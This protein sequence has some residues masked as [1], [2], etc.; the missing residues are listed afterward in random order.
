MVHLNYISGRK[1]QS[2]II[3]QTRE[4]RLQCFIKIVFH[5]TTRYSASLTLKMVCIILGCILK[6]SYEILQYWRAAISVSQDMR[7]VHYFHKPDSG[8][9]NL[10]WHILLKQLF[11]NK[12]KMQANNSSTCVVHTP[13][14]PRSRTFNGFH[15][16]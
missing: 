16:L 14:I 2:L 11:N 15:H 13:E 6:Y 9:L 7:K 1:I 4:K 10:S 12:L 3:Q 5:N 8:I